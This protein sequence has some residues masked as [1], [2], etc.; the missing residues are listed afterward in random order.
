MHF[1]PNPLLDEQK[2]LSPSTLYSLIDRQYKLV[3]VYDIDFHIT[4]TIIFLHHSAVSECNGM[5]YNVKD[6]YQVTGLA[7]Q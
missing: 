5:R 4:V 7:K 2:F 6:Y 1:L 3:G